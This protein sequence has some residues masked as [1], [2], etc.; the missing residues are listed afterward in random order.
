[1]MTS[2]TA[3]ETSEFTALIGVTGSGIPLIKLSALVKASGGRCWQH[4]G[5]AALLPQEKLIAAQ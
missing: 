1:M 2:E 5:Q 4:E 3:F